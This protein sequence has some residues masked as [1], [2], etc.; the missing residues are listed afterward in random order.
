M[1][2][3]EGNR[4]FMYRR[5]RVRY[6]H[7]IFL[8]PLTCSTRCASW[9]CE[10]SGKCGIGADVPRRLA[11]WVYIVVGIC[12]FGGELYVAYP[13]CVT[14]TRHEG[15]FGTL[16]GL[17]F[18]HSKQRDADREKRVQYWREQVRE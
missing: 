11:I 8:A 16:V 5:Q 12:I 14:L 2:E 9:N 18:W 13:T 15:M 17:F 1:S 7:L 3:G 6:I 10:P 4:G